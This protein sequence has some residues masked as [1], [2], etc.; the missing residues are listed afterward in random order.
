[1]YQ[2]KKKRVDKWERQ[3]LQKLPPFLLIRYLNN[4]SDYLNI[5]MCFFFT[6]SINNAENNCCSLITIYN[7][8]GRQLTVLA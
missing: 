5:Y 4:N 8:N 7:N 2:K 3:P 1:M 6:S